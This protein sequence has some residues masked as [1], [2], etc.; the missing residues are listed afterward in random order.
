M[1]VSLDATKETTPGFEP[2]L[3]DSVEVL[4]K[5]GTRPDWIMLG[6]KMKSILG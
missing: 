1:P 6:S 2:V 4:K 3:G 5:Q